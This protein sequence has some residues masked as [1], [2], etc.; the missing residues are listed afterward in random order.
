MSTVLPVS[1]DGVTVL[2]K[3][4]TIAKKI[5]IGQVL[6]SIL[7]PAKHYSLLFNNMKIQ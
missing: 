4:S 7:T 3:H 1:I 2:P 5:Q 6:S